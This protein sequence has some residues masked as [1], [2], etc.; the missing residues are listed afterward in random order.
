VVFNGT[1]QRALEKR[2]YREGG[3][4]RPVGAVYNR[5]QQRA[6]L[7][8]APTEKGPQDRPVGAV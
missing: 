1:R 4:N 5:A 2:A 6:R 7:K 3:R 8:S